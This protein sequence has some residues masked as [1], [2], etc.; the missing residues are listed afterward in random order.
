M[1]ALNAICCEEL[2]AKPKPQRPHPFDQRP[3]RKLTG[4]DDT[5]DVISPS[6]DDSDEETP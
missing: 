6:D 5:S 3:P 4:N 1:G 2:K